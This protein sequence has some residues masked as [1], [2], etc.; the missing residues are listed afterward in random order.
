MAEGLVGTAGDHYRAAIKDDPGDVELRL[1]YVVNSLMMLHHWHQ[2]RREADTIVSLDPNHLR[3][4]HALGIIEHQC[5]DAEAAIAAYDRA[6]AI[7]P[8]DIKVRLD[9]A[10]LALD[11]GDF[12]TVVVMCDPI[13]KTGK[14]S[15]GD[16]LALLGL[17]AYRDGAY[18]DSIKLFDRGLEAGCFDPF[19]MRSNRANPLLGLGRWKEGWAENEC[20]YQQQADPVLGIEC[21]R[22]DRPMWAC[23]PAPARIHVHQEMGYGDLFCLARYL[24]LL[25]E[26]GY[27]VSFEV[28]S[29]LVSLMARSFPGVKVMARARDF[30]GTL[31]IPD[32]DYHIPMMSLPFMFDTEVDT[33]PWR[34]PYIKAPP[35]NTV[36][37]STR[38]RVG[39]C[40]SSAAL[41]D[42]IKIYAY[43]RRKSVPADE[44]WPL[45]MNGKD[46]FFSLQV[47]EARGE[48]KTISVADVLPAKPTWDDTAAL[49]E[50]LDLVIAVDTGVAHLAAA[51]G[52][53]TW[54]MMHNRGSW[55]WLMERPGKSWNT[56]SP[57]YPSV[58]IFRQQKTNEWGDV[59]DQVKRA[60]AEGMEA[61]A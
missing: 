42:S 36:L 21:K 45:L 56:R 1:E 60:L 41:K 40:W 16:A 15:V 26:R 51:M 47:G 44:L 19:A 30:P 8:R 54:L 46:Q 55:H 11:L 13:V 28:E 33:I 24:P 34:G 38:R 48:I 3:G 18:E 5:N 20:R 10:S 12:R 25:V 53:P 31:G 23:Q 7:E 61:A 49:I 37:P 35:A 14:A 58:R 6:L 4:W 43:G 57:W 50:S 52:K 9:R 32:F 29:S 27:E 2:A 22:F 59:I 17:A 39:L